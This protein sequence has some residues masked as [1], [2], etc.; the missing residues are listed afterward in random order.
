MR[1]TGSHD[2]AVKDVFVPAEHTLD[3]FF[4]QSSVPGP[5]FKFPLLEFSVHIAT[6]AVGIAQGALDD[7]VKFV[8]TKKQR[9]YARAPLAET[10]LVQYRLGHAETT[11][12]AARALLHT[13]AARVWQLAVAGDEADPVTLTTRI[14]ATDAWVAQTCA[15]IVDTCYT[16]GGG[17]SV[18]DSS[19]LQRRLRDIHTLTQH[20]SLSESALTRA[21][22]AL[23]GQEIG[24]GF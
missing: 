21:G 2:I 13:E 6:V 4:G 18:Y 5:L 12:R 15:T 19:P 16:V 14:L 1:G 23:A 3:I 10:P 11:L 24:F 20:A 22:A 8:G 17:P 9:L 7:L